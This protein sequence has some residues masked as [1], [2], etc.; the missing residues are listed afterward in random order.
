MHFVV[1]KAANAG[2]RKFYISQKDRYGGLFLRVF[3]LYYNIIIT[4]TLDND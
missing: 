3:A 1:E 4:K 2:S